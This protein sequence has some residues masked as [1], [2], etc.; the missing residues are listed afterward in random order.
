MI[1]L[2]SCA[3][4]VTSTEALYVWNMI[5]LLKKNKTKQL[6]CFTQSLIKSLIIC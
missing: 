2:E 4:P 1:K 6:L 3:P 5:I